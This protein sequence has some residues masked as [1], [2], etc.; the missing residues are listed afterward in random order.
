MALWGR[1]KGAARSSCFNPF[2]PAGGG[3]GGRGLGGGGEHGEEGGE[4]AK[5]HIG[6]LSWATERS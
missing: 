2:G 4:G 6:R 5:V 1:Q 3:G